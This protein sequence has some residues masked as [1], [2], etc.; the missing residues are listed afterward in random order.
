MTEVIRL[1]LT[2]HE[3]LLTGCSLNFR[4]VI[5]GLLLLQSKMH[6]ESWIRLDGSQEKKVY[7]QIR[8][9]TLLHSKTNLC[10][11]SYHACDPSAVE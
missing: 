2:G 3:Y 9:C 8:G 1:L 6:V 5:G 10:A 7:S 11:P 4:K